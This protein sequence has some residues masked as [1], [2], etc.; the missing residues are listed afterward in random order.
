M[1]KNFIWYEF[2]ENMCIIKF[3]YVETQFILNVMK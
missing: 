1:S 2:I 3:F